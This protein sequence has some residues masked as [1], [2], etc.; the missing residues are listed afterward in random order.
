M[1][2]P[3]AIAAISIVLALAGTREAAS[4]GPQAGEVLA[5]SGQC[6]GETDGQR[7]PLKPGDA[8]HVG[9]TLAVAAGAKLKLRMNDGSIIAI[10]S[11][12][13]LT[14]AAYRVGDGGDSRDATLSLGEGL[15]RAVVSTLR[16]PPHFEVD[17]A[18][19]VAAVRSTDWFIE[20]RPGSTLVGVLEGRVSLKSVAT[21]REIV[22]PARWGRPSR[23]RQRSGGGKS[24]DPGGIRRFHQPHEFV[25]RAAVTLP[26]RVRSASLALIS[27]AVVALLFT[28]FADHPLLRGLETASLDLRFR[29]RGVRPPGS[30]V[31]VV[32]VDDRSLEAFGRWPFSRTRFV[33]ALEVLDHAGTKVVAFDLLFTEADETVPADLRDAARAAAEA[34]AGEHSEGLRAALERLADSDRDGRFAVAIRAYGHVLLPKGLSFVD[35]LGEEPA[36]L[37]QSTY[38]RFEKS[39]LMPVFPFRSTSAVLPI[40]TLAVVAAGLAHATITYDRDGAPR[41]DYAALPFEGDFL[42]SLSIGGRLSWRRLAG[43]RACARRRP[44]HRRSYGADR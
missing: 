33:Q 1:R 17:T 31:T 44:P 13:R 38:V 37:S 24:V 28:I 29:L 15:L 14:I 8:V 26:R 30:E 43:G 18:T 4:A 35:T 23:S 39:P 7:R 22:I 20:A 6:F 32:L 21:G 5:L 19:S 10:A 12:G 16:G 34:L 27:A 2:N 42:P 3:Y 40:E 41:Y 25:G 9:E 11:G 36:W